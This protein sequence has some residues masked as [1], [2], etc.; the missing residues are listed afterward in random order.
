MTLDEQFARDVQKIVRS[1][2]FPDYWIASFDRYNSDTWNRTMGRVLTYEY[3]DFGISAV[4]HYKQQI[5]L[6]LIDTNGLCETP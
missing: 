2:H 3:L 5:W 1:H 4:D 6:H